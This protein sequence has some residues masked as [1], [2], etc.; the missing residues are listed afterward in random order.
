LT[1]AIWRQH[2][3]KGIPQ[4]SSSP[5]Q[6]HDNT[7]T[8]RPD[9]PLNSVILAAAAGAALGA[10]AVWVRMRG[11]SAT[12]EDERAKRRA[13]RGEIVAHKCCAILA[14][15]KEAEPVVVD[16]VKPELHYLP[17]KLP[18][19]VWDELGDLAVS[20]LALMLLFFSW[21]DSNLFRI[22]HASHLGPCWALAHL[23][24]S[25]HVRGHRRRLVGCGVGVWEA[26]ALFLVRCPF[27]LP[28]ELGPK[29]TIF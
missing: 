17:P 3:L 2:I 1:S 21:D 15:L 27:R 5:T 14:E 20:I 26:W 29:L 28:L 11:S 24:Y 16:N 22:P 8:M 4:T 12:L 25:L 10:A 23:T 19:A 6:R 13:L 18:R 7:T 9:S